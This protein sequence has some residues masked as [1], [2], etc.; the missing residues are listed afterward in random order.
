MSKAH[1]LSV[2]R[3]CGCVGL[4][5]AA[6]YAERVGLDLSARSRLVRV[7]ERL[8]AERGLPNVL[9]VDNGREFL[10]QVLVDWCQTNGVFIRYIQPGKPN[11]NAYIEHFNRTYHNEV[12][13]LYLFRNLGEAREITSRWQ[14]ECNELRP[15]DARVGC[16]RVFMLPRVPK[17]LL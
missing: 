2:T 3:S 16:H 4:T 8:K 5:R 17:T 10:S 15:H 12:L 14:I 11:Q 6:Y 1:G 7:F 9:R 13:N